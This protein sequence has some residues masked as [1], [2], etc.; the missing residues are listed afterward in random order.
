MMIRCTTLLALAVCLETGLPAQEPVPNSGVVIKTETRLVLVDTVVTDKKGAYITDLKAKDFKVYEDNKEQPIK[1][2]SFGADPATANQQKHYMVL[3]FD[4]TTIDAGNQ[5]RARDAAARFIE[6][7]AGANRMIAVVNFTGTLRIAQ[8]FTDNVDLLKKAVAAMKFS[9]TGDL[10]TTGGGSSAAAAGGIGGGL[11]TPASGGGAMPQLDAASDFAVRGAILAIR[12]LAKN[13]GAIQGRKIL[14]LLT[15]GMPI[16]PDQLSE[17]TATLDV[18]NRANVAIYPIDIRGLVAGGVPIA[19]APAPHFSP[20]HALSNIGALFQPASY[21]TMV[22]SFQRGGGGGGAGGGGGGGAG[23]GGG[24]GRGGGGAGAGGGVGGGAGAGGGRGGI[25]SP[26]AGGGR[27][28]APAGAG[29]RGGALGGGQMPNGVNPLGLPNPYNQSR[30]LLPKLPESPIANQEIMHM[31][32]DG[33]GGFV[34]ENANDLLAGL[35]KIGREENEYYLLGYTPP[36]TE[37][38]SCH[39]L[40]VKVDRGGANVRSRTGY[41]NPRSRDVLKN[42]PIEKELENRAA[43]TQAGDV[44]AALRAPFFY[45]SPNVA[46]VNVAME[47][48]TQNLKFAK[49]KGKM[50]AALNVLG[51]AYLPDGSV[52]ARFSDTVNLDFPDKKAVEEF[53]SQ[54]YHYENQFDVASGKYNLKIVFSSGG[55]NFGKLEAPLAVEP[56]QPNEFA[57]SGLALS[58]QFTAANALGT[59]LDATLLEDKTPLIANNVRV[60]PTGSSDFT[61]SKPPLFYCE[62]YEPLLTAPDPKNPLVVAFQIRIVDRKTGE[63]KEDTGILRIDLPKDSGNPVIRM[64]ERIPIDKLAPGAYTLEMDAMDNSGKT[65]KRLTDFDL[66]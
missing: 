21:P 1:N 44:A 29:G 41:C 9:S 3:F 45:T 35:Q 28:G 24:G 50:H 64:A 30:D 51:I 25:G 17:V 2:F 43:A 58:D 18:C 20:F 62:V 27:G 22:S 12:N 65:A 63:Q 49:E 56:Y 23:A 26:G 39:V 11:T 60:I 46:R 16:G 15:G 36:D 48:A 66:K 5:A 8:N 37:E 13:L 54:P 10:I 6:T 61:K 42:N 57:L 33:T 38:G 40:R 31:L 7:N 59:G 4:T 32:A 14:V 34:I 55:E 53:Q 19:S 52:G 47:I